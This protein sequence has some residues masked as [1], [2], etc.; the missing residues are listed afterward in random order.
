MDL[1]THSKQMLHLAAEG[2]TQGVWY[3]AAL[4]AF[5][6]C[7]Y[8]LWFQIRTRGWPSAEGRLEHLGIKKF[9]VGER[10]ASNQDYIGK[11]LYTYTVAG[12]QY[13]GSRISPWIIIV[14]HNSRFL[15]A[16]QQGGINVDPDGGVRVYYNPRN[17][18]K[19]YLKI[20]GKPGIA[21]TILFAV[22]PLVSYWLEYHA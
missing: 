5:V 8:S 22:A 17:P 13:E 3:W 6:V 20:A 7:S 4:Y 18:R 14:S 11:A 12:R 9:G 1:L 15:L 16:Q 10:S 2:H 19:S 21:V